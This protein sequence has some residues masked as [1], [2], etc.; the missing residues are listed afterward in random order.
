V[1]GPEVQN[2]PDPTVDRHHPDDPRPGFDLHSIVDPTAPGINTDIHECQH[3][4]PQS[5]SAYVC[6]GVLAERIP[7][8]PP[9]AEACGGGS[10]EVP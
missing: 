10:S 4:M 3:L 9:G 6:S 1:G 2:C 8:N 7:G 5:T